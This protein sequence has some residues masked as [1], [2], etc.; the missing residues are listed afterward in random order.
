MKSSNA[1]PP[2]PK[3]S[4]NDTRQKYRTLGQSRLKDIEIHLDRFVI[5]IFR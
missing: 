3:T 1:K 2:P 5:I 4:F